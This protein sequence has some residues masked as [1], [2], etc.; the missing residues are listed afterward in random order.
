VKR[1]ETD[2][3][4]RAFMAIP[5]ADRTGKRVDRE[6]DVGE[7]ECI[8]IKIRRGIWKAFCEIAA[9]RGVTPIELFDDVLID[10]VVDNL[11]DYRKFTDLIDE[12]NTLRPLP[13]C[14][15]TFSEP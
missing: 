6:T 4:E 11:Q 12:D 9:K 13:G 15:K 10:Y 14:L 3:G 8:S 2:F 1:D 7:T 5:S